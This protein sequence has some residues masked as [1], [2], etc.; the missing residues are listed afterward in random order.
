MRVTLPA[1]ASVISV[2]PSAEEPSC[3]SRAHQ[4]VDLCAVPRGPPGRARRRHHRALL[5]T[6][7]AVAFGVLIAF[8]LAL[9]AR[10]YPRLESAVLGVSTGLYTIPSLALF[11]LLV[12]FTGLTATTVVIGLGLYALTILVRSMLSGFGPS[13]TT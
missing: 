1:A 5:I 11:P 9:L 4:R 13:P 8:P 2:L 6:V 7:A 3:Y 12:P 10:R